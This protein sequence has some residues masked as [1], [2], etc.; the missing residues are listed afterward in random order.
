MTLHYLENP[1]EV[2]HTTRRKLLWDQH[3]FDIGDESTYKQILDNNLSKTGNL[4]NDNERGNHIFVSELVQGKFPSSSRD[5]E[6]INNQVDDAGESI[7]P[8]TLNIEK[9]LDDLEDILVELQAM[10]K[11]QA[12]AGLATNGNED[13]D[14]SASLELTTCELITASQSLLG[15]THHILLSRCRR[16]HIDAIELLLTHCAATLTEKQS[17]ELMARFLPSVHA[18]LESQRCRLGNYHPDVAR[19]YNDYSMGIQALLS[20]S[21]K[22]LLSLKLEGMGTLDEC[23]KMEHC[24]RVEKKR[25]EEMYPRDADEILNSVQRI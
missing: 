14:R 5:G 25:I 24:C 11:L 4:F 16:L 13:F 9:S 20:Y 8:T 7:L 3:R 17:V 19:S 6:I 10:F 23:S 22:K 1:R 18:L 12:D 15:N 21:P 2:S